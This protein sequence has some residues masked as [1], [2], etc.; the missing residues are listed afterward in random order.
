MKKIFKA[1][2]VLTATAAVG[3]GVG[4]AAG[5]NAGTNGTYYGEYHYMGAHGSVYGMVVEV[6]VEN[7][8]IKKVT[9]LTNSDNSYAK[10]VQGS[11][12]WTFISPANTTW[13][14]PEESVKNWTDHESWL[15][16]QYEG[17]SVADVLEIP[18][19]TDYA[20]VSDNNGGYVQDRGTMGEPC[21]VDYNAELGSSGLLLSGA[22][23]GSGRV[24][25]AV[26]NALSK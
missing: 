8:I 22:T 9:N 13:G 3:A 21:K 25:L 6:T 1:I 19:Y 12:T 20:Y 10:D 24:L 23:Q 15:F 14:W 5:C 4:I 16:Q 2:A 11:D 26:Q 17:R 7:N 18:V